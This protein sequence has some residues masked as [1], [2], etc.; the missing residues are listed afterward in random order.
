MK[1]SIILLVAFLMLFSFVGCGEAN[2][3]SLQED[4]ALLSVLSSETPFVTEKGTTVYLNDYK[5][6]YKYPE[7][8]DYYEEDNVFVPRDYTFVDLDKDGQNEL[9]ISELPDADTYLILHKSNDK[10]YGYSLYVRWFQSLK[11]DG[12]FLSSGG[13]FSH[14][15]NT[16][17]FDENKYNISTFATFDFVG[18]EK[19]SSNR[20]GCEPDYEKSVFEIDGKK[21]SFEKIEAFA[22]EWEKRP[23]AAWI[24]IA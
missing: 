16:I 10:I 1:K 19:P 17:N 5:P 15:Y 9:I 4:S 11:S 14:V 21:V 23:D 20:F 3:L 8:I 7:D 18:N 2:T 13:A 6:F 12:T 22:E 24:K